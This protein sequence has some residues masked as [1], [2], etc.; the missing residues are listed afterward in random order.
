MQLPDDF[1]LDGEA[2]AHCS[3][4]LPDFHGLLQRLSHHGRSY[5]LG[6]APFQAFYSND[7][8]RGVI[9]INSDSRSLPFRVVTASAPQRPKYLLWLRARTSGPRGLSDCEAANRQGV[10]TGPLDV[11]PGDRVHCLPT[12]SPTWRLDMPC[13]ALRESIGGTEHGVAAEH[14]Q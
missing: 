13:S 2:V 9:G 10:T 14:L 11:S 6:R 4:G 5:A 3:Q 8:R 12:M 1:V 7:D